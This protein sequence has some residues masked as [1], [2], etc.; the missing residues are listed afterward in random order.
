VDLALAAV[1]A[2]DVSTDRNAVLRALEQYAAELNDT[3]VREDVERRIEQER[4]WDRAYAALEAEL[5]SL[6][7]AA[8]ARGDVAAVERVIAG[9]GERDRALGSRRPDTWQQIELALDARLERARNR[10]DQL[11]AY[12]ARRPLL[13][14]Y[15][16]RIRQA[17][18]TLDGAAPCCRPWMARRRH[19]TPSGP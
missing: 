5:L 19:S 16:R 8:A 10:A 15:E 12:R 18:S 11:A 14:A 3:A 2:S 6:T 13:L 17:L 1:A 9:A 4:R 7:D